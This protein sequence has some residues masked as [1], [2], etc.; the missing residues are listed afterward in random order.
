MKTDELYGKRIDYMYFFEESK[1][2]T[3]FIQDCI[4]SDEYTTL[5]LMRKT[6]FIQYGTYGKDNNHTIQMISNSDFRTIFQVLRNNFEFKFTSQFIPAQITNNVFITIK[7]I[8]KDDKDFLINE[9]IKDS[10][11]DKEK[12]KKL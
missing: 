1:K 4:S 5:Y 8:N 2:L 12:T 11:K 6:N 3:K 9:A 7:S 10:H